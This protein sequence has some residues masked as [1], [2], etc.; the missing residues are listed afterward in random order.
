M[1][2]LLKNGHD[3]DVKNTYNRMPLLLAAENGHKEVVKLLLATD[4]VDL[5][6]KDKDG[7]TLC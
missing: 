5:N 3:P 4:S 1:M 2:A 6:S 7:R